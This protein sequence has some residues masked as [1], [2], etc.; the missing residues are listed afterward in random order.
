MD[1]ILVRDKRV[2]ANGTRRI[3][4]KDFDAKLHEKVEEPKAEP[5]KKVVK[6]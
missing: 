5:V 3:D 4:S 6:E 1:T 2:P